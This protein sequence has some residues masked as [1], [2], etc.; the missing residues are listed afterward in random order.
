MVFGRKKEPEKK[1]E[2]PKVDP[3]VEWK[4]FAGGDELLAKALYT[5]TPPYNVDLAK[6]LENY[7]DKPENALQMYENT[8]QSNSTMQALRRAVQ[9][10]VAKNDP[11]NLPPYA[12]RCA[13]VVPRLTE[14]YLYVAEN[15]SKLTEYYWK[16]RSQWEHEEKVIE[17]AGKP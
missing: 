14:V 16:R 17:P 1:Q 4:D 12:K 15:P 11:D 8:P 9:Y 2:I 10:F 13:E 7:K 5:I 3:L 6:C